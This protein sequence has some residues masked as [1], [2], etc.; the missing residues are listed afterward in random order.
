MY[1]FRVAKKDTDQK[2]LVQR[3]FSTP[4]L[5]L[6]DRPW[7]Q[8]FLFSPRKPG[9]V[10]TRS[11]DTLDRPFVGRNRTQLKVNRQR[12]FGI[13]FPPCRQGRSDR[14]ACLLQHQRCPHI[15]VI[16]QIL[17]NGLHTFGGTG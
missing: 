14:V 1:T 17:L 13:S 7:Y 15:K 6:K 16:F 4:G 2:D 10:L 12:R 3:R 9:F 8:E 11:L 5:A